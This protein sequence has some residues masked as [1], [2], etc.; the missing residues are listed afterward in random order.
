MK[1]RLR[2]TVKGWV[3]GTPIHAAATTI[4]EKRAEATRQTQANRFWDGFHRA[5]AA[6]QT[7]GSEAGDPIDY[8]RHAFLYA[9]SVSVPL[10]GVADRWWLDEIGAR[11]LSPAPGRLLA[12]GCGLAQAEEHLLRRDYAREVIAYDA[13]AEA[14]QTARARLATT[15]LS[16]RIE[17]RC[18][19]PL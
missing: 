13:S 15:E 14:I 5:D 10:T 17:L 2:Q 18:G 9:H 4:R 1:S 8:T 7:N 11:Y 3:A 16:S 19:D 12:L 6:L